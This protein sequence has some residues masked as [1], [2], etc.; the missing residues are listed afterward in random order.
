M[1]K[2]LEQRHERLFNKLFES[3][4]VKIKEIGIPEKTALKTVKKQEELDDEALEEVHAHRPDELGTDDEQE[5]ETAVE[6]EEEVTDEE[7][8]DLLKDL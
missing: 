5:E 4:G 6:D 2:I 8:D 7:V 1:K 3:Q